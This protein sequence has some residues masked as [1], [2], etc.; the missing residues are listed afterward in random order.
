MDRAALDAYS[1]RDIATACEFLRDYENL[2][3]AMGRPE[4]P[5]PP[6]A[7]SM[8]T[9][10]EVLAPLLELNADCAAEEARAG[11]SASTSRLPGRPV[12]RAR[13]VPGRRAARQMGSDE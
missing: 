2:R 1:W 13:R 9:G 11:N 4:V 12:V 7:G 3:G 6:S 10:D 5:A 8:N